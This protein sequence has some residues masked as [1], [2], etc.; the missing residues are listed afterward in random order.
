MWPAE[1][2]A[3]LLWSKSI[4]GE[5]T[6]L[7]SC[8]GEQGLSC[9][10]LVWNRDYFTLE[11]KLYWELLSSSVIVSN[12]CSNKFFNVHNMFVFFS[13]K[14]KL[15]FKIEEELFHFTDNS[16]R[17]KLPHLSL[18]I[19]TPTSN[20]KNPLIAETFQHP[21][22]ASVNFPPHS[23]WRLPRGMEQQTSKVFS[24][25]PQKPPARNQLGGPP[26]THCDKRQAHVGPG[27]WSLNNSLLLC[28]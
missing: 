18:Y 27:I 8:C 3:I 16:I 24:A 19:L 11:K 21:F 26:S 7:P 25:S 28:H 6:S 23:G 10:S 13:V 22:V 20:G 9:S 1:E 14:N 2:L 12:I 17:G 5:N 15:G 4:G